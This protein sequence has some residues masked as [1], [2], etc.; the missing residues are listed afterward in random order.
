MI[1]AV[2]K[3]FENIRVEFRAALHCSATQA[4]TI[5]EILAIRILRAYELLS[6]GLHLTSS[7]LLIAAARA[8]VKVDRG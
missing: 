7:I 5:R 2:R 8:C 1:S 3:A 4:V 6:A